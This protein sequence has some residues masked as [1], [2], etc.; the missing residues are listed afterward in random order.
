MSIKIVNCRT[1]S[2][3]SL[4]GI[5]QYPT[6]HTGYETFYLIDQIIDPGFHLHKICAQSTLRMLMNLADSM[7]VPF[8]LNHLP[9]GTPNKT[10]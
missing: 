5:G 8:N 4:S 1:T 2:V 7:I 3:T 9:E 6:Y 10:I